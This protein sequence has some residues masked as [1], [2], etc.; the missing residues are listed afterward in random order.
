MA[1]RCTK[2][3]VFSPEKN[4]GPSKVCGFS[5]SL[6]VCLAGG[7]FEGLPF[8]ALFSFLYLNGAD[9]SPGEDL[10]SLL[11]K[12]RKLFSQ[13]RTRLP[14]LD[15]DKKRKESLLQLTEQL[16]IAVKKVD[17]RGEVLDN[18]DVKREE[19]ET[20]MQEL[21]ATDH[22]NRSV[23]GQI[24]KRKRHLQEREKIIQVREEDCDLWEESVKSLEAQALDESISA[25]STVS[26]ASDIEK[27]QIVESKAKRWSVWPF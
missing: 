13:G 14:C 3:E 17:H 26:A 4:E 2:I 24:R 8:D 21:R 12:S 15:E 22:N 18:F 23:A 6:Q 5:P 19:N 7:F 20:L 1:Q 27:T 16:E 11:L 10:T 25:E 9:V